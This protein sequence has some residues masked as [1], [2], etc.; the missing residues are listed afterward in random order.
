MS[1]SCD[2]EFGREHLKLRLP[3]GADLLAM[4][5]GEPLADPA[6]AVRAGLVQPIGSAPLAQLVREKRALKPELVAAVVISDNTRPV[7]Y[8]GE[9]GILAPVLDTLRAE[10]VARI[11]ILVATGTH[12]PLSGDELRAMLPAAAFA[13]GVEVINHVCTDRDSLV[14]LGATPR[15]TEV[16]INRRYVEADVKVL[17]GLVEPHFCAGASGGPKSICPGMVGEDVTRVFHGAEILADPRSTSMVLDGN[18]CQQEARAVAAMAGSDFIVNV[19]LDGEKRITG[20]Y[21]GEVSAAHAAA[22]GHLADTAT[23]SISAEYDLVLTHAGFAGINHYQAAKAAVEGVK[24][25]RHGG[26]MILAA[27]HTD[28]DP[29]GGPDYRRV[30]RLLRELGAERFEER[31]LSPGWEFVHEQWE[32][33]LWARA[34]AKLGSAERLVYCSPQLTGTA[35]ADAHVPARHGGEG[36]D[37][38][39]APRE[40]AEKAVQ[41]AIDTFAAANPGARAVVLLDGPYAVPVPKR[42]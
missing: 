40:F 33:Q 26:T 13:D 29:V 10:G 22:V 34:L 2:L 3:E 23:V 41:R 37:A 5:G 24:A 35:F 15:G 25:L 31:L 1:V 9:A 4:S 28:V 6:G 32:P 17:T 19:T 8:R 20:V 14:R 27:N 12:R 18:P 38:D 42:D 16:W 7:P 30:L 39:L 36:L 11:E 21:C